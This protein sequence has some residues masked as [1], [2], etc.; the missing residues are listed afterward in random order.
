[1][2]TTVRTSDII[3][4][5]EFWLCLKNTSPSQKNIHLLYQYYCK[6]QNVFKKK[7]IKLIYV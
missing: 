5:V 4:S 3:L 2:L 6:Q 7:N 1:M